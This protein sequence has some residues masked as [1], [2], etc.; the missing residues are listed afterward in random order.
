MLLPDSVHTLDT[1][2][3]A[4]FGARLQSLI[5][6]TP[7]SAA[8][9]APL[10]TLAI[11]DGLGPEDLRACAARVA[12]WHD[13]GLDTPLLLAAQE[14]ERSLD[15]F[16]F[17]FGAILADHTVVSGPD[18]FAGLRVDPAHMRH[19]CEIQARSHLLH[20]RENYLETRGRG[21]AIADLILQ[22]APGFSALIRSVARLNGS[23]G[24][25]AEADARAVEAAA[26]IPGGAAQSIVRLASAASLSPDSARP[27]MP[28]Y[29]DALHR[30]TSYIDRW[31]AS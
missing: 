1:D 14:F 6:Y 23:N 15:A 27:L 22:S 3:R 21:D 12:G 18:P 9:G 13:A 26:G 5:A 10:P 31:S 19:A 2:L 11:V 24:S 25:D 29:I 4:V 20:L 30:L 7:A 8:P 28:P 17:E 16:P